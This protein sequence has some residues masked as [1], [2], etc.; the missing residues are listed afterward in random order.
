[1]LTG[2]GLSAARYLC[3]GERQDIAR[4]IVGGMMRVTL[5]AFVLLAGCSDRPAP[6]KT[7]TV[8]AL[9]DDLV[10]YAMA[11][12]FTYQN[13]AYLKEQGWRWAGAIMQNAHGPVEK[14]A[15]VAAAVKAEL[16]RSGIAQGQG[17][18]P[19]APTLP[20]PVMTCGEIAAAPPVRQA[21]EV[22]MKALAKDDRAT[23]AQ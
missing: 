7:E 21:V 2:W 12:C 5:M 17:E 23:P 8:S 3:D 16:A 22:A 6:T 4:R 19:R 20:L 13:N 11:S 14:W 18:G 10:A 1:M 9:R 15:P